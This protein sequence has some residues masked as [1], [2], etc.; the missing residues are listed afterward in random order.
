MSIHFLSDDEDNLDYEEVYTKYEYSLFAAM[1]YLSNNWYVF[2]DVVL[3]NSWL[4]DILRRDG[5]ESFIADL[6]AIRPVSD[7]LK[8]VMGKFVEYWKDKQIGNYDI[9]VLP[10]VDPLRIGSMTLE[11]IFQIKSHVESS[12]YAADFHRDVYHL[13]PH[14]DNLHVGKVWDS[15]PVFD[16]FDV[17]DN[18]TYQNYIIRDYVIPDEEMKR[19][20]SIL[21]PINGC[22][23]HE[24]I[25]E[26]LLPMV[27]Y[28]GG[29]GFMTVAAKRGELSW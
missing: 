16:S 4:R 20:A 23:V 10:I 21:G 18:R 5:A 12:I 11:D 29:G 1:K 2:E 7:G 15:Y 13:E 25:P 6:S 3:H 19:F 28:R 27:Y 9:Q 24:W 14:T 26:D 17:G 8:W 22:R